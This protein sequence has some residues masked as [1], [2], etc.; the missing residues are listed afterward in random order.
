MRVE[1]TGTVGGYISCLIQQASTSDLSSS[2]TKRSRKASSRAE[3]Y[4]RTVQ[5]SKSPCGIGVD[6]QLFCLSSIKKPCAIHLSW[7]V[8]ANFHNQYNTIITHVLGSICPCTATESLLIFSFCIALG[9]A[10][11]TPYQIWCSL[12]QWSWLITCY[13]AELIASC[14]RTPVWC[15][16]R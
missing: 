15:Y 2:G 6:I 9:Q 11:L 16:N 7:F 8:R 10:I 14:T 3:R 12:N 13:S 5:P 4:S 1:L